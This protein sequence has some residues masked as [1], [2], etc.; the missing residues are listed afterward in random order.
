MK[1]IEFI[2]PISPPFNG[3]GVKN[4]IIVDELENKNKLYS[5]NTL[6]VFFLLQYV[7]HVF[8]S[9]R[10]ER[11]VILSVSKKGRFVLSPIILILTYFSFKRSLILIPAGGQFHIELSQLPL[12]LRKFYIKIIKSYN[13]I[14]V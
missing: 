2:G 6:K 7:L 13:K 14:I 8:K 4:K 1:Q 10:A 12:F 9:L 11:T 3:P 5:F